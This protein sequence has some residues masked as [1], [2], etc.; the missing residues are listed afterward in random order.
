MTRTRVDRL[1]NSG[2]SELIITDRDAVRRELVDDPVD[3]GL[4]ADVDAARRL[5][6]DQDPAVRPS[7]LAMRDLLLV[8]TAERADRRV[9]G[10]GLHLQSLKVSGRLPTRFVFAQHA[11]P[12]PQ[13][14]EHR[15][16]EVL[17]ASSS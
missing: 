7:H 14:L 4:G 17:Q 9:D 8:A 15:E 3:R 6:D 11:E 13:A 5:V 2:N 1:I 12:A 10:G 16:R